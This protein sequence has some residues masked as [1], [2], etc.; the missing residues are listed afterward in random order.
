MWFERPYRALCICIYLF[1]F[2]Y[3]AGD[4]SG[5]AVLNGSMIIGKEMIKVL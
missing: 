3:C 5:C 4:S 2:I 1:V